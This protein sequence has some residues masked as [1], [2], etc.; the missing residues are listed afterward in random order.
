MKDQ[1]INTAQAVQVHT[2]LGAKCSV[3]VHWGSYNLTD[4]SPDQSVRDFAQARLASGLR[5]KDFFMMKIGVAWPLPART[6]QP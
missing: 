1:H 6:A 2:T 5:K 3:G 4:E